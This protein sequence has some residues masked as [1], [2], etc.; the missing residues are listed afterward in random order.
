MLIVSHDYRVVQEKLPGAWLD[1]DHWNA[2]NGFTP[3]AG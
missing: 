3:V 1:C 2:G